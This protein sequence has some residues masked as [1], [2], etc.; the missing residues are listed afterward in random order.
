VRAV[1]FFDHFRC[2]ISGRRG[3]QKLT[4]SPEPGAAL[5]DANTIPTI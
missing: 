4:R 3:G 2:N 1:Y 5:A